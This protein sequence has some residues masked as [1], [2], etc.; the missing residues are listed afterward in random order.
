[1]GGVA[2]DVGP[3]A[4]ADLVHGASLVSFDGFDAEIELGGDF[5][6]AIALG[7]QAQHF[8]LPV[9]ELISLKKL[10]AGTLAHEG[11]N[12]ASRHVRIEVDASASDQANGTNQVFGGSALEQIAR[13]ARFQNFAQVALIFV[14]GES[15]H[16]DRRAGL[17][18]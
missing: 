1:M 2:D 17:L 6:V 12:N 16:V 9:A 18:E 14:D 10:L 4:Q 11:P 8:G 5:L 3:A 13:G 7:N 15:Q